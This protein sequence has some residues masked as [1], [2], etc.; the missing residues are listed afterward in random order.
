MKKHLIVILFVLVSMLACACSPVAASTP[1]VEAAGDYPLDIKTN[2]EAVD[3]VLA[4]VASG[5]IQEL[6]SLIRYTTAPC[7][8]ADGLGG[9]PKCREG[10]AEGTLLE[11]LP[12]M[13]GEGSFLRKNDIGNWPGVDASAVYAVY[14]VAKDVQVEEYYPSG[15]YAIVF[16]GPPNQ[17]AVSVRIDD[18]G[19]VR[20][21]SLFDTSP[22]ALKLVMER[23]ALE[24]ILAPKS[25]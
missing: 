7:T 10:E 2:V 8:T 24:V 3:K 4:A 14:R 5:N 12:F 11:I 18:G 17:P 23:D 13:E 20:I 21:D 22:E 6:R 15:E 16:L 19:I 25:R 1:V 9:P